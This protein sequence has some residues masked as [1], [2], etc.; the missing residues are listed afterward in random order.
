MLAV[1]AAYSQH[2]LTEADVMTDLP[3][4]SRRWLTLASL[5]LVSMA[6][7]GCAATGPAPAAASN[8]G[9]QAGNAR[10]ATK[11]SSSVFLQ[12]VAPD[13]RIVYVEGHNTSS[14]Q[15]VNFTPQVVAALTQRGYQVTNNPDHAQFILQYNL[16]Y[17]GKETQDHTATGALAG[18]FGGAILEGAAGGSGIQSVRGGIVGAGIGALVGY[19]MSENQYMMVVDI[20]IRQRN[21][22]ARTTTTTTTGEGLGNTTTSSSTGA[23]GW[24]TYSDRVVGEAAGRHLSFD[25]AKPALEQN[26]A[27]SIAGIF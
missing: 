3:H 4:P 23:S 2:P 26:I 10:I 18:G 25:Y 6:L 9:T 1:K 24:Q 19:L 8:G 15:D 7:A 21:A 17:L 27:N 12:P 14:A 5:A 22:S 11:M 16:R 20:Q 13:Q